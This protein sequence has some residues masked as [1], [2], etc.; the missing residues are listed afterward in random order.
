MKVSPSFGMLVPGEGGPATLEFTV[1]ID[2]TTAK[3]LNAG[4]E[5]LDDILILRLEGGRD[6]YLTVKAQYARSCFGMSLEE[7]VM[8]T[9]SIRSI[10]MDPIQKTEKMDPH[11]NGSTALCVPKELWR[12]VDA[13]IHKGLDT[14]GLFT[15]AGIADEVAHIREA[16]DTE[17]QFGTYRTHS[18]A[19]ALISFLASLSAPVI[20][21][22]LFPSLEI[23]S[24]NIQSF[25]RRV[26]DE[27]PP[28]HYNVFVYIVSLFR[29]ALVHRQNNQLTSAKAARIIC[30][31][32]APTNMESISNQELN[33]RTGMQLILIHL[34]ETGS[35]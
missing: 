15:E 19:E 32:L 17:A 13:I 10:P 14:P 16:L 24:Q 23:D 27:L 22:A 2:N 30:D 29:K 26:L 20:P 35:I 33:K 3:N 18:Y 4:R 8:Y 1:T 6:Y 12:I 31:C 34:L 9:K 25:A 11:T 7:L 21:P 28:I 5:V